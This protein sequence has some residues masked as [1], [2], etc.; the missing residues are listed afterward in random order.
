M[1][2]IQECIDT[3]EVEDDDYDTDEGSVIINFQHHHAI[4][5]MK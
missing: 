4:P 2:E 5:Q 3:E 1:E